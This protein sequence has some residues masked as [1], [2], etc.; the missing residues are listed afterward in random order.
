[1]QRSRYIDRLDPLQPGSS[2]FQHRVDTTGHVLIPA[3]RL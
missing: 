2:S 3:A 1:M